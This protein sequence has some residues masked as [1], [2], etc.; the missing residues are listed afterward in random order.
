MFS[1]LKPALSRAVGI[2]AQGRRLRPNA[3]STR[4]WASPLWKAGRAAASSW[5]RDLGTVPDGFREKLSEWGIWSYKVMMFERSKKGEFLPP[6]SYRE[7]ALVTFATHDLPTYAGWWGAHDIEV[8]RS[9]GLVAGESPR[10]AESCLRGAEARARARERAARFCGCSPLSRAS[11]VAAFCC[12]DR[13]PA[14]CARS[15]QSARDDRYPPEL[16]SAPPCCSGILGPTRGRSRCGGGHADGRPR[17]AGFETLQ[18]LVSQAI[19]LVP[20]L[21]RWYPG[22]SNCR[23]RRVVSFSEVRGS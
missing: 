9:L 11:A 10:A 5:A 14:W 16:A 6:V 12:A 17:C 18:S 7:D 8:R 4:C 1:V 20:R 22:Q 21:S 2:F 15:G 23:H 3:A 13:G 19:T